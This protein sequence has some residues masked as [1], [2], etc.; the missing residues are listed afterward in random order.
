ML[1]REDFLRLS[2]ETNLF[3]Q[4]IM[5]EHLFFI[6][7]S[8]QPIETARIAEADRLKKN[9][10]EL[11]EES[12]DYAQ[13]I[14]L[15]EEAI[16]SNEF[17]TPYTLKAE[18]RSSRL[19]GASINTD[20]TKREL[21]LFGT[22]EYYTERL[23]LDIR[24]LNA[25]SLSLLQE[26]INYQ[27]NILAL[28]LRC[29]IF[30]TLYADLLS[31]VT[32]EAEYYQERLTALQNRRL[33]RRTL[34]EE[35]NFWN[36]VMGDHARFIACMLDPTEM[37]LREAAENIAERFDILIERCMRTPEREIIGRSLAAT[38]RVRNFKRA[39]TEGILAC[40]IISI[41]LPLLA[42]HVLRE[43]NHYL[44]ILREY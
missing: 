8:L 34:C 20:I 33:P 43:A 22:Q 2:L 15:S 9:F 44:R 40:E 11:L 26:V 28:S 38:E 36:H 29:E 42:D 4:R 14:N 39:A 19:T 37:R 41:I 23:D 3:F 32:Q 18:K 7:T 6:E 16:H 30:I 17:V 25:R 1:S 5:K 24:D 27:R 12:V 35:L 31:H 10:E 13:R 21:A